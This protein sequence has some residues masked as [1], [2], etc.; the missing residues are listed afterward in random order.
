LL[1]AESVHFAYRP[2]RPVLSNVSTAFKPGRVTAIIGPNGAGKSTLLR[3]LAGLS[4]PRSGRVSL[5]GRD[6]AS[7]GARALAGRIAYVPQRPAVMFAFTVGQVVRLGRYAVGH[8]DKA[9]TRALETAEAID[10]I[11]EPFG[12]LSVGQQQRV[13]LARALAQLDRAGGSSENSSDDA[14]ALVA[15]EPVSAMD[16]R[17]AIA[18]MGLLRSVARRGVSVVVVLHDLTLASCWA[19]DAVVLDDHGTIVAAGCTADALDPQILA[20]VFQTRF[21]RTPLGGDNADWALTPVPIG[22]DIL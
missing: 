15:D 11:D 17:H 22:D 4:R 19:D 9:V 21:V 20:R 6:V 13:T 14:I 2:D 12:T 16:P 8:N 7:L 3:L 5:G 10:L 18:S 1:K